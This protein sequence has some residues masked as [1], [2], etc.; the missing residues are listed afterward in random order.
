M[1]IRNPV[2]VIHMFS[3]W[4]LVT[5]AYLNKLYKDH[6]VIYLQWMKFMICKLHHDTIAFKKSWELK[7]VQFESSPTLLT[8]Y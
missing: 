1:G 8:T 3:D 2:G 4:T 5:V 7:A 6:G